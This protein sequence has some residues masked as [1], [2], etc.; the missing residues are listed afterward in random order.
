MST[1]FVKF[2]PEQQVAAQAY[3]TACSVAYSALVGE[4]GGI[5]AII[6][7]DKNNNWTVPLF[8]QPWEWVT[9][10]P[11]AEPANCLALRADAVVVD[12]PEWPVEEE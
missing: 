4:V 8:G 7:Q 10:T 2:P 1:K 5:W 9:G 6:R 3:C 11:V 12:T